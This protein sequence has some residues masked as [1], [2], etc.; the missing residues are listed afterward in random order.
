LPFRSLAKGPP[1]LNPAS[2]HPRIGSACLY[3]SPRIQSARKLQPI[4][5]NS[6]IFP[7]ATRAN[8]PM[9]IDQTTLI[10]IESEQMQAVGEWLRLCFLV[11]AM[12]C[13]F[14]SVVVLPAVSRRQI[15][16][17]ERRRIIRSSEVLFVMAFIILGMDLLMHQ[18]NDASSL[19][20][21][22]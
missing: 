20:L 1:E 15:D 3:T 18:V 4:K 2:Q 10:G 7:Q 11:F 16:P 6:L 22:Q 8:R 5:H 9:G 13:L 12:L 19:P 17:I 21:V 14:L